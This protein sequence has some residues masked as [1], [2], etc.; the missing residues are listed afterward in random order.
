M[1]QDIDG[2]KIIYIGTCF[3]LILFIFVGFLP[4]AVIGGY[5]GLKLTEIIF[6]SNS[7]GVLAELLSFLCMIGAVGLSAVS[8][9]FGGTLLGYFVAKKLGKIG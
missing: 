9:I 3:G 4:I 7:T 6:G 8:L 1:L 5:I 2:R